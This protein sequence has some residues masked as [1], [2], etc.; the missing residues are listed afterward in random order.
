MREE[1]SASIVSAE[2]DEAPV[3]IIT[4]QPEPIRKKQLT[5]ILE[6]ENEGSSFSTS[7]NRSTRPSVFS[8]LKKVE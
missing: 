6:E 3:A 7:L 5:M 8:A 1:D 2:S 4:P